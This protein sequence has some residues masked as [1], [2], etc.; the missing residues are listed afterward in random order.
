GLPVLAA[1]LFVLMVGS[2]L[3]PPHNKPQEMDFVGFG[4]LPVAHLGRVKPID[5]LA[6]NSVRALTINSESAKTAEGKKIP[7]VQWLLEVMSGSDES[8][9]MPI[10]RI[11]SKEVRRVFDLEDRPGFYY[12]V[13]ELQPKIGEFEKQ[14]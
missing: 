13:K 4:R 9:E 8:L 5:T 10:I 7:A 3:R 12:A 6:R 2:A 1:G 14:A 11:D